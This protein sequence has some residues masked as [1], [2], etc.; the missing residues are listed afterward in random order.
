MMIDKNLDKNAVK[1]NGEEL[2]QLSGGVTDE[3]TKNE[4]GTKG[5]KLKT[6]NP[7]STN[8][9]PDNGDSL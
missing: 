9:D 7:W 1:L 3:T 4:N 5:T 2:E 8:P 6:A